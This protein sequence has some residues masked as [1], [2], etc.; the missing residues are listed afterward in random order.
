M[1][2]PFVTP[3]LNVAR[4][5]RS[6]GRNGEVVVAEL[7][8]LPFCLREG[9]RVWLT[10]PALRGPHDRIVRSVRPYGDA[11]LVRFSGVDDISSAHEIVGDLVMALR[12][13]VPD[14]VMAHR[15]RDAEGR[16]VIDAQRGLIGVITEVMELPAND[17]WV[18]N[19]G[20]FGEILV[21]V[22]DDV[23]DELAEDGDIRVTLLPGLIDEERLRE[24][25]AGTA[26][27]GDDDSGN[28]SGLDRSQDAK[29][30]KDDEF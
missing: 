12:S 29:A 26:A 5:V 14:A 9:M 13:D 28:E 15:V 2:K 3:Y 6:H 24:G 8:G 11:A 21:P 25:G 27:F 22:I 7:D 20:R 1:A 19:G 10:P 16:R 18:V 23:V 4:V 30:H 17:V